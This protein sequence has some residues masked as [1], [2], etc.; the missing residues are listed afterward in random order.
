[1][2]DYLCSKDWNWSKNRY[3][4]A[5]GSERFQKKDPTL[6]QQV[7]VTLLL[8]TKAEQLPIQVAL[9]SK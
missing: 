3:R 1:M 5:Q 4:S 7:P 9:L 6:C 2:V 8:Q